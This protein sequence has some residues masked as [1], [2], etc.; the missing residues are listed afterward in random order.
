MKKLNTYIIEKLVINK[1]SKNIND[2]E[3][4]IDKIKESLGWFIEDIDNEKEILDIIKRW[5]NN[6]DVSEMRCYVPDGYFADFNDKCPK[7]KEGDYFYH[8]FGF[9]DWDNYDKLMD[10]LAKDGGKFS[11]Q[12]TK[13]REDI[14]INWTMNNIMLKLFIT[15]FKNYTHHMEIVF[16]KQ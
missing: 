14:S 1:D 12:N 16:V 3:M 6:N 7:F 2:S 11:S 10:N 4:I 13:L 8:K 9:P 15:F 5:V